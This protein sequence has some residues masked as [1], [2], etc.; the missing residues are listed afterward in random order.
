MSTLIRGLGRLFLFLA[1]GAT[2]A[3]LWAQQPPLTT[4]RDTVYRADGTPY[5][6]LALIE[7]KTFQAS[8]NANIGTQGTTVQIVNGNLYVRLTPTTTANNAYYLVRYNSNGQFQ[9]SEIW[10]VPASSAALRLRDIRATLLPGGILTGGG[11]GGAVVGEISGGGAIPGFG[12]AEMPA[13]AINGVNPI[14]VLST[15]PSPAASLALFRNGLLQTAGSDYTLNGPTITF[16]SWSIPQID[17]VLEAYYRTA[18]TGSTSNHALLGTL[19]NDTTP[20]NPTRGG[21]I[22]GQGNT[23]TWTQLPLGQAGRCLTSN[24]ADAVWNACLYTGLAPG[25][26]PFVDSVGNLTQN[27]ST[28]VYNNL[29]RKFSIGNNTPRATLNVH[30]A[31]SAG[32]TELTVRAGISQGSVPMQ[33]WISNAGQ[34]LAFVNADGGFN[35][36]RL[37][38]NS[39]N[40]RPGFSDAGTANDPTPSFLSDGDLWFNTGSRARKTFESGQTHSMVQVICSSAGSTT[41]VTSFTELGTCSLPAGLL[42]T[43][44]RLQIEATY[45]HT[46]GSVTAELDVLAGSATLAGRAVSAGD[47]VYTLN[48]SVGFGTDMAAWSAQTTGVASGTNVSVGQTAF[49]SGNAFGPLKLRSRLVTAGADSMRLINYTV[50]RIPQQSNP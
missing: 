33:T 24:G 8:N 19:H 27:T 1:L 14:F 21:L 42:F 48:L 37:L 49:T 34:S 4:I 5:N 13:G 30:D 47:D 26:I 11:S 9:F 29:N 40:I 10:S 41:T 38:T 43:G 31:S 12:D 2:G 39:S 35:V 32:T 18:A 45:M 16:N 28:L 7:W 22:V 20:G 3:R 44:D 46:G 15:A 25:S 23:P 17:D 36:R 50:R 6:G